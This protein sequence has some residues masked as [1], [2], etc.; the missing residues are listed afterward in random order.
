MT[1]RVLS[2][3]T[4]FIW[5]TGIFTRLNF[6]S[7]SFLRIFRDFEV[8]ITCSQY[9][10]CVCARYGRNC[11]RGAGRAAI[12][13]RERVTNIDILGGIQRRASD[14][15]ATGIFYTETL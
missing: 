13:A 8:R 7:E 2:E 14:Y 4:K 1:L 11:Q 10:I 12:G 15:A 9:I 5:V 6:N 3:Y